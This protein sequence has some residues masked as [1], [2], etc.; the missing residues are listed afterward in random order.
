MS[1]TGDTTTGDRA[2]ATTSTPARLRSPWRAVA[3]PSEHGG[4]ALTI[5]PA[6]LGLAVM[7]SLAGGLLAVAAVVAFLAR[8]PLR[9]L[10]VDHHRGRAH[11]RT[12]RARLVLA[13]EGAVLVVVLAGAAVTASDPF[14][15]PAA[16]AAPLVALELW[17]DMRSRSR[18]LTPELAGA[19][20]VASVA[21]MI[22]LA[23]GG[24]P[25][26][27]IALWS[28]LAARSISS[29][30]HV[31]TLVARLHG[32]V[33][34]PSPERIAGATALVLLAAAVAC[35]RAVLVGALAGALV[36]IWQLV[37]DHQATRVTIIGVR[38][39]IFGAVVVAAT[40]IGTHLA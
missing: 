35:D 39:M 31:R 40:A 23:G 22:V 19:V 10:L 1:T 20:G 7:P 11:E 24:A 29:I 26:L 34:P 32:R 2:T 15:W 33:A 38:Q 28:V 13:G 4:W 27:A 18:R 3:L 6:V 12:R 21:T 37:G 5:E 14:W 8:T 17:F 16:V 25:S 36:V 30:T 9:V